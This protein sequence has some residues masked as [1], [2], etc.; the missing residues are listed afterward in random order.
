VRVAVI[1]DFTPD[2]VSAI[3]GG[4]LTWLPGLWVE[5]GAFSAP[6]DLGYHAGVGDL[7]IQLS[8]PLFGRFVAVRGQKAGSPAGRQG[9]QH[10]T[11]DAQGAFTLCRPTRKPARSKRS[12]CFVFPDPDPGRPR[13]A[14]SP[15]KSTTCLSFLI[16]RIW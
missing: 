15:G 7:S 4:S 16:Y 2:Q 9:P 3:A 13:K 1:D 10:D 11:H 8:A 14:K 12:T 5:T 6:L